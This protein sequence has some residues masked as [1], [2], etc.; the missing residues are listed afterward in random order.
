VVISLFRSS[1]DEIAQG[2]AK[3]GRPV[4]A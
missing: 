4:E 3:T 1:A 2:I